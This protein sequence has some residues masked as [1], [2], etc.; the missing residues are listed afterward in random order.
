MNAFVDWRNRGRCAGQDP[1]RWVIENLPKRHR[2]VFAREL[3]AG[4][5]TDVRF[6]CLR[7][8][9]EMKLTGMVVDGRLIKGDYM[10]NKAAED[11]GLMPPEPRRSSGPRKGYPR[12]CAECDTQMRP[13]G[14]CTEEYPD[15]LVH[16]G[17][18]LC[19]VCYK[20]DHWR[21]Q[22]ELVSA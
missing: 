1:E 22:R 7:N 6:A 17:R 19:S 11:L 2:A 12:A 10:L 15:T 8:A 5:P 18:D 3:C 9:V 20:A 13:Q 14:T 4:C 21:R 16:K